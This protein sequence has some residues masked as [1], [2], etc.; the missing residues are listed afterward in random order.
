MANPIPTL[1]AVNF[2]GS[3]NVQVFPLLNG[4]T[5]DAQDGN[6]VTTTLEIPSTTVHNNHANRLIEAFGKRF[7]VHGLRVYE[8][9]EGG[10][11]NWGQVDG[12]S[13]SAGSTDHSG[14]HL[15]NPNGVQ[16][17]AFLFRVGT[18]LHVMS[19]TTGVG[20]WT[21]TI[22]SL[23]IGSGLS[24]GHS[25]VFRDSI[26]WWSEGSDGNF[27][28]SYDLNLGIASEF[29][30]TTIDLNDSGGAAFHVHQDELF[31]VS[32]DTG[33]DPTIW[34]LDGSTFNVVIE[35]FAGTVLD[36]TVPALWSDGDD[37][38]AAVRFS[39]VNPPGALRVSD[40]LSG[41]S[42]S[43]LNINGIFVGVGL[44][45]GQTGGLFPFVSIDPDPSTAEQRVFLWIRDG[46]NNSGTFD[47]FRFNYR[48]ITH[49]TVTGGP[50]VLGEVVTQTTSGATGIVTDVGVGD[51]S[52]TDVTGT[53]DATNTLTGGT[54]GATATATSLLL[55]VAVTS[56]GGGISGSNFG[57]GNVTSGGLNRIPTKGVARIE[58]NGQPTEVGG[59]RRRPCTVFGTGA[60]IDV[61]LFFSSNSEAPDKRGTIGAITVASMPVTMGLVGNLGEVALE[62]LSP[63]SGDAYVVSA[64]DGDASLTPGALAIAVGDIVEFDGANWTFVHDT[65]TTGFPDFTTHAQLSTTTAL[66][67]PYTDTVDDGKKVAFDGTSLTGIL[68]S[69][70]TVVSNEARNLTPTNGATT[71][72]LDHNADADS[73][74]EA[75]RHTVVL[76][77]V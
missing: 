48:E 38:I 56:L 61:A 21:E 74:A 28:R 55:D 57:V 31:F 20:A 1:F 64:V 33:N 62:A 2:K 16:T 19:T 26:F 25:I 36:A 71:F 75:D 76:D 49:G 3:G 9:D 23:D 51:L 44:A 67:A 22:T 58:F 18:T 4:I 32:K 6:D 14:L 54:S 39:A 73:I 50:F 27:I 7:L 46:D 15:L 30:P 10:A 70:P 77:I 68:L 5:L 72:N 37:I 35:L 40:V 65:G 66:I 43:V 11:G 42:P 8:R 34:R 29:N 41:G 53:F 12:Q 52:L 45:N 69:V 13:R 60:D 63:A 24:I 47:L 17:L 59:A